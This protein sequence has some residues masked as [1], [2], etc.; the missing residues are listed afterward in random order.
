MSITNRLLRIEQRV[1]KPKPEA[2]PEPFDVF[3]DSNTALIEQLLENYNCPPDGPSDFWLRSTPGFSDALLEEYFKS[4]HPLLS[5]EKVRTNVQH[6][7]E[8]LE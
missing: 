4:E 3:I 8:L 7:R 2:E 1:P 6:A 5:P